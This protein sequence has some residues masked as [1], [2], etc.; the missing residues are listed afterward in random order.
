M[1]VALADTDAEREKALLDVKVSPFDERPDVLAAVVRPLAGLAPELQDVMCW[2]WVADNTP[3]LSHDSYASAEVAR[4]LAF[5][6]RALSSRLG[7]F[8]RSAKRHGDSVQWLRAGQPAQV[9][10]RGGLSALISGICDQLYPDAP[11]S[12]TSCSIGI[13][14][15]APPPRPNAADRRPV[16]SQQSAFP[17]DR[18]PKVASREIDVSLRDRQRRRHVP[19]SDGFLRSSSPTRI[20]IRFGSARLLITSSSRLPKRAA[21]GCRSPA[22]SPSLKNAPTACATAWL[23]CSRHHTPDEKPR[24]GHL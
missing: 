15:V 7:K 17:R 9:P 19:T 4:Q 11:R 10:P 5:A 21:N 12:R 13:R 14:S 20:T 16:P 1:V 8:R 24:N 22:C 3:E 23:R 6:R 2:Q 18:P